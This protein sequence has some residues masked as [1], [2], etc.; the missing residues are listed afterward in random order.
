LGRAVTESS[1][2]FDRLAS[3]YDG[4]FE[5]PHRKL[6]DELAWDQVAALLPGRPGLV[7]DAGCGT[8]RWAPRL[9]ELGHRVIGV[10]V[11]KEMASAAAARARGLPDGSF[12]VLHADIAEVELEAGMA[13]VVLAMGSLQYTVNPADVLKR[14]AA[15]LR[16]GGHATV[17]VDSLVGLIVELL[18]AGRSD[19]AVARAT[20]KRAIWS[21]NEAPGTHTRLHL[22]NRSDLEALFSDAAFVDVRSAG[23]LVETVCRG[24]A[25][26]VPRGGEDWRRRRSSELRL[27]GIDVLADLGKHLMVTGRQ[28]GDA[29]VAGQ[30]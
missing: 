13:D 25:R 21:P 30:T 20:S 22:F 2:V 17:L 23:L 4:H 12:T 6:Y 14:F 28:P 1:A 24:D 27:T 19:E 11:S 9:A 18:A 7:I 15:W 16:P 29:Q 3:G 8:G 10:E 5:V 26:S